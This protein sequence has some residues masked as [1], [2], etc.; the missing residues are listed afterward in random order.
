MTSV[1]D[2]Q[3]KI[4]E[5]RQLKL[6]IEN[7]FALVDQLLRQ[8]SEFCCSDPVGDDPIMQAIDEIGKTMNEKFEDKKYLTRQWML[9]VR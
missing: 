4:E 8:V 5:S 3:M 9:L 1:E 6:D 2:N 7:E